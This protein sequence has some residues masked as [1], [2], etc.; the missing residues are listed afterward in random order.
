PFRLH[1]YAIVAGQRFRYVNYRANAMSSPPWLPCQF[2]G[3]YR[4]RWVA[5]TA[6]STIAQCIARWG[7]WKISSAGPDYSA[8][9]SFFLDDLIYDPSNG[10]VSGGDIILSQKTG[11][12]R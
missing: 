1:R 5:G 3:P 4:T 8:N 12:R 10:T 6:D 9:T 7:M 11:Q 2:P